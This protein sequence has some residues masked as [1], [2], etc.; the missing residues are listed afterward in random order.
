VRVFRASPRN[1]STCHSIYQTTRDHILQNSN[2][3]YRIIETHQ[4]LV[5]AD[6]VNLLADNMGTVKRNTQ[7]LIDGSKEIGLGVNTD[8]TKYML[9][10][11]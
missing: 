1:W 9:A 7:T 6:D 8:K 10:A 11:P 5:Y 4:L 3:Q 2:L